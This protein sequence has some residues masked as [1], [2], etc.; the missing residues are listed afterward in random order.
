MYL[1]NLDMSIFNENFIY[2]NTDDL[3]SNFYVKASGILFPDPTYCITRENSSTV[4]FATVLSGNCFLTTKEGSY[5]LHKG[6]CYIAKS[7]E[8]G[9]IETDPN[10]PHSMLWINCGG[11]AIEKLIEIYL[12]TKSALICT[13]KLD[14]IFNQINEKLLS[15]PRINHLHILP[16]LIEI[17][18]DMTDS[19][20]QN[21]TPEESVSVSLGSRIE[22]YI[23]NGIQEEFSL[24]KLCRHFYISKNNIIKIFKTKYNCTPYEY[25]L[26]IKTDLAKSMLL[27]TNLSIDDIAERLHF[28][29]RNHFSHF[30]K[31]REGISPARFR[32]Q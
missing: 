16:Y 8:Y 31:N 21:L 2:T 18:A 32:K 15:E 13:C 29:D 1:Y 7:Y 27:E 6:D 22:S 28:W 23:V 12:G 19:K 14:S 30:F 24:D 17:L 9:K 3:D 25:H 10:N 26:K 11:I 5:C 20:K 4:V